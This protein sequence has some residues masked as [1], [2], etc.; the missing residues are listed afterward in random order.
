MTLSVALSNAL[1]GLTVASRQA[2]LVSDNVANALTEG[3][4]RRSLDVSSASIG[5]V[6][7]GARVTG[8]TRTASPAITEARRNAEAE[9]GYAAALSE[10]QTRL[11]DAVGLPGEPQ[12]LG[13]RADAL[14]ATLAAAADTPESLALLDAAAVAAHDYANKINRIAIEANSLRGE[15]DASIAQQ[16]SILNR[17]L[18]Q[19][20]SLNGQIRAIELAGGD[21]A[22]LEDERQRLI[23][24]LSGMI[25]IRVV[26]RDAGD[27][28]LFARN[29][30]QLLDGRAFEIGFTATPVV[31]QS[32][33]LANGGLSGITLAGIAIEVGDDGGRGLLDGGSLSASFELRD[34]VLPEFLESLDAMASDLIQRVEGLPEDPTLLL[35]SPGLFTDSGGPFDPLATEGLALRLD[36]S[37]RVDPFAGG[38]PSLL[39]DG[40]NALAPGEPGNASVLRGLQDALTAQSVA[41]GATGFSGDFGAA[42]LAAELAGRTIAS[43]RVADDRS[44]LTQG[45]LDGLKDA[46]LA[47]TGV[48]TDQELSRL[49]VVEQMFAANARVIEVIDSLL[50]RL[51]QI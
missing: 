11:A 46:E 4:A 18:E 42:E 47:E 37:E 50:A 44:S 51:N 25:P 12:S 10:A 17:N 5:G 36:L 49:L 8:V 38:D 21:S 20:E 28:A 34:R 24:E 26:R 39:R 32:Q 27:V 33:T 31:T 43:S 15:T 2:D 45:R 6:G 9:T 14:D 30:A 29:G 13:A 48:D 16:V 22:A 19:I 7:S 1:S 35:G 41:P 3:Y 40:L 23:D